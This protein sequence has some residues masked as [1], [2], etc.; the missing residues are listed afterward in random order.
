M[1]VTASSFASST[2]S[3]GFDALSS[4]EV[5]VIPRAEVATHA[6]AASCWVVFRGQVVDATTYIHSHP[7]G[8]HTILE[9]AGGDIT[10]VFGAMG[11]SPAAVATLQRRVIGV[12]PPAELPAVAAVPAVREKPAAPPNDSWLA[13]GVKVSAAVTIFTGLTALWGK[14]QFP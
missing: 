2:A 7:G 11:H 6:S 4:G 13:V 8:V 10:T 14:V 3:A 9:H 12:L 1:A 5:A